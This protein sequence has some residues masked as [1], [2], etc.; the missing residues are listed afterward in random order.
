MKQELMFIAI[1][2]F[3]AD[4]FNRKDWLWISAKPLVLSDFAR[5]L[6]RPMSVS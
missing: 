4:T 5:G 6:S 2:R 1:G 3:F